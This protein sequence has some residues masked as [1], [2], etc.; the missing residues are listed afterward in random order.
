MR[1]TECTLGD[2]PFVSVIEVVEVV[3]V[4]EVSEVEDNQVQY[5]QILIAMKI[6]YDV[7]VAYSLWCLGYYHDAAHYLVHI[8]CWLSIRPTY[9]LWVTH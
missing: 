3:E 9:I 1:A 6:F 8:T 5:L 7:K 2:C 4:S